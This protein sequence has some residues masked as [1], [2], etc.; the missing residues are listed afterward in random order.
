MHIIKKIIGHFDSS[1]INREN[2]LKR[3]KLQKLYLYSDAPLIFC[4]VLPGCLVIA[5]N[6]TMLIDG[7][8]VIR[9]VTVC[10]F[11]TDFSRDRLKAPM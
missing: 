9:G 6:W 8:S 1:F 5:A 7:A 11:A 10:T 3:N 4:L 2:H